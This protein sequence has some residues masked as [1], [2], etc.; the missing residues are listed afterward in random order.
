MSRKTDQPI[1]FPAQFELR[2]Y[3]EAV[4]QLEGAARGVATCVLKHDDFTSPQAFAV[5]LSTV[6]FTRSALEPFNRSRELRLADPNS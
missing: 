6:N 2:A 1:R 4:A 3:A 5:Y